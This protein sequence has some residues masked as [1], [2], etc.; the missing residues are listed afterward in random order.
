MTFTI[1]WLITPERAPEQSIALVTKL[2]TYAEN[3]NPTLDQ[4][5]ALSTLEVVALMTLVEYL[6]QQQSGAH[7]ALMKD[8]GLPKKARKTAGR[9]IHRLESKGISCKVTDQRSGSLEIQFEQLPSYMTIPTGDGL[10]VNLLSNVT[11][12]FKWISP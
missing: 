8:A 5:K 6:E 9:A 7:L 3:E 11:K 2:L 4:A 1:D 10:T 12:L